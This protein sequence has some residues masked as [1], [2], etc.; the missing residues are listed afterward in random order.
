MVAAEPDTGISQ[1]DRSRLWK[2]WEDFDAPPGFRAEI[3]EGDIILS[4]SPTS[5]HSLIF[6]DLNRQIGPLGSEQ[7]WYFTAE[8]GVRVE[9]TGEVFIPD[10]VAVPAVVLT[11]G[12]ETSVIDSQDL[13]LA[14]EITSDSTYKRDRKTKLW[15]YSYGL[16]PIYL[17][18]DRHDR[19]GTVTVYSKP[20]GKGNYLH[21]DPVAFGKPVQ[22]PEPFGIDID[23]SRFQ[24][25]KQ[26]RS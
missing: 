14:V 19:N 11:E 24:A 2:T 22:L 1:A 26:N 12:E 4:P 17:L 20:D 3:I 13:L 10:L 16:V 7:D 15:S 21:H 18:V 23:T 25:K 5:K 9:H 8:I 6:A